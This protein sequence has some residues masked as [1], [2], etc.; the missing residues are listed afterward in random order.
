MKVK[1]K[2]CDKKVNEK[3]ML[4]DVDKGKE[5]CKKCY[6]KQWKEGIYRRVMPLKGNVLEGWQ[7]E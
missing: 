5:I 7:A 3:K 6:N 2:I 4:W 1:C